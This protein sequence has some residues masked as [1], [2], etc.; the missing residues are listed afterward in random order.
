MGLL[1]LGR[2]LV[3]AGATGLVVHQAQCPMLFF[4]LP[5]GAKVASAG[6]QGTLGLL[7]PPYRVIFPR[8]ELS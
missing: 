6:M 4:V 8:E 1:E 7:F 5:W 2:K 3:N